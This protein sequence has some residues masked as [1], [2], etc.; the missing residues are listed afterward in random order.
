MHYKIEDE[1]EVIV[2]SEYAAKSILQQSNWLLEWINELP[3][4]SVILDYGCGK[5]RYTIPLLNRVKE[6]IA[7][8]SKEQINRTQKLDRVNHLTITDFAEEEDNLSV[9]TT[10]EFDMANYFDWAI[11]TNVLSAI[12]YEEE[13]VNVLTTIRKALKFEGKALITTQYRNSY[14]KSYESKKNAVKY[15]D[16]WLIKNNNNY[17]FYGIIP[18]SSLRDLCEKAGLKVIECRSVGESAYLLI[19][20]DEEN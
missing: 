3:Q 18:P 2:K 8:D 19:K 11:C 7:V 20:N 12:P 9:F 6:V 1:K 13:R 16:G 17:S 14:F 5:L 15:K 4:S 10:D